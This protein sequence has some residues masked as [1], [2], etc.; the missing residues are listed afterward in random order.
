MWTTPYGVVGAGADTFVGDYGHWDENRNL[1]FD[2]R[3][4][5]I[6]NINGRKVIPSVRWKTRM[7]DVPGGEGGSGQ[8]SHSGAA[9]IR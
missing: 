3:R 9:M 7:L 8:S 5:D 4:D 2:G 1:Y 6:C